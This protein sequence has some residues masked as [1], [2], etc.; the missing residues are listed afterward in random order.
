M[1]SKFGKKFPI[2]PRKKR[3]SLEKIVFEKRGRKRRRILSYVKSE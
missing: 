2:N 1:V 3:N